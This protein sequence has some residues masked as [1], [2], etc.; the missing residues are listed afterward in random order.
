MPNKR[1]NEG[2]PADI[3]KLDDDGHDYANW[4][5]RI[6]KWCTV[7]K[8][9]ISMRAT[10]IQLTLGEKG[11][12]ATKYISE[13]IL[14]SNTG[15]AAL[16]EELDKLYI[17]DKLGK[18]IVVFR[19]LYDLRRK[20]NGCVLD[21][22]QEFMKLFREYRSLST[23]LNHED[24]SLALELMASCRLSEED[25]KIVTAQ[26]E[27][28]PSS[29]NI[30]K[31]LKRIFSIAKQEKAI[32]DN[33]KESD[34]FLAKSEENNES[35]TAHNT[36]YGKSNNRRGMYRQ[37]R[38][39]RSGSRSRPWSR[40]QDFRKKNPL[41]TDGRTLNCTFCDSVYHFI[42]N[43]P[44]ADKYKREYKKRKY[45]NQEVNLS[46]ISFVGCASK[47]DEKLLELLKDSQGYALLDSGC[48]NTVA[49]EDWMS[50]YM[51]NLSVSDRLK[52]KVE[53]SNESFTFG[54]GNTHEALRRITFPCWVGGKPAD[55]TADIVKC[56]IPLLLSRKSMSKVGMVVDFGRHT[57][58]INDREIKLKKTDSGHYALPISL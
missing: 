58:T 54:D 46:F 19:Q 22:I 55:I 10:N 5:I 44:E 25:T 39:G 18:R 16:I 3:P 11:F 50:Q 20:E 43:C 13:E 48:S 47:N 34:I 33:E 29:E 51:K 37:G 42:R 52:I 36:F 30:I 26:M 56:K 9:K 17:P 28:P 49:G 57:A 40:N 27:E 35:E 12:E 6:K 32:K 1:Q 23:N 31:I 53:S 38:R 7:S 24:S 14:K 41:G 15:V 45:D 21:H 2:K 8:E 4:K